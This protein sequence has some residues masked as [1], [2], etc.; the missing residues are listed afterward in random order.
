VCAHHSRLWN[1]H[2]V[3]K[4]LVAKK[5]AALVPVR[6]RFYALAVMLHHLLGEQTV[7]SS[8]SSDATGPSSRGFD[9]GTNTKSFTLQTISRQI[10]DQSDG[11]FLDMEFRSS[12]LRQEKCETGE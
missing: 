4:P 2:L 11:F 1:R 5:H 9:A 10:R 8:R 7:P 6:D 12:D 3:I